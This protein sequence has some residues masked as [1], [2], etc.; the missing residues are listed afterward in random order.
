[1]LRVVQKPKR[2]L[3]RNRQ[4][5]R[6]LAIRQRVLRDV[7]NVDL[8]TTFLG[9]ELPMPVAVAPMGGLVVFHPQG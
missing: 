8:R 2:P 4:A 7:R 5:I 9:M 6:K 1:M 3:R